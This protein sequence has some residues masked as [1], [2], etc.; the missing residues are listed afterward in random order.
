LLSAERQVAEIRRATLTDDTTVLADAAHSL[1]SAARS[2]GALALSEL[3][4]RLE[5][6]GRNGDAPSCAA[7]VQPLTEAFAA[8][9]HEIQIHLNLTR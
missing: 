9:A 8:A 6:A 1:K 2:V 3:C 5:T 7:L 4:Q